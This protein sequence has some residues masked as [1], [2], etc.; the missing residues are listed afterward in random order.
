[1]SSGQ[2]LR[3]VLGFQFGLGF[4]RP[5]SGSLVR[6][7]ACRLAWALTGHFARRL[8]CT[9]A[10]VLTCG[11]SDLAPAC[12]TAGIRGSLARGFPPAEPA[13]SIQSVHSGPLTSQIP[14]DSGDN[15][16]QQRPRRQS[17]RSME[18]LHRIHQRPKGSIPRA[19]SQTQGRPFRAAFLSGA[20]RL[21]VLIPSANPCTM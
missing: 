15:R 5:C 14:G 17:A 6:G 11:P 13:A 12:R 21:R 9:L 16:A 3:S 20:R 10:R 4:R 8:A 18:P 7:L 19:S 1:M 2:P